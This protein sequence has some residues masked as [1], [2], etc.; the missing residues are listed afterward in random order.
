MESQPSGDSWDRLADDELLAP[1]LL[2]AGRTD[3]AI[4]LYRELDVEEQRL[5]QVGYQLLAEPDRLDEAISVFL[6]NTELFP[7]SSNTWDSLGEG[8]LEAGKTELAIANYEKSLALD[9]SNT[10]A[11]AMLERLRER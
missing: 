1:E 11:V 8:Y 6:L 9:P 5:N 7:S 4:A 3:K 2:L 10:N